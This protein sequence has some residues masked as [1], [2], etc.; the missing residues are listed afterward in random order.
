MSI[1]LGAEIIEKHFTLD[2]KMKGPDHKASLDLKE[3]KIFI[4]KVK[5]ACTILGCEQKK[6]NKSELKNIKLVRKSIRAKNF[7]KK[8]DKFSEYNI[9]PKRPADGLSPMLW[10]KVIGKIAKK[11][12]KEDDKIE[13]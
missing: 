11:N 6:A 9:I 5:N 3:L 12:F 2:K 1:S 13:I 4:E 8:G 10:N 7:I